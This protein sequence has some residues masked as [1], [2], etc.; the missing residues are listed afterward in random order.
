MGGRGS[1]YLIN[2][3]CDLVEKL[4]DTNILMGGKIE[5]GII[6]YPVLKEL[7]FLKSVSGIVGKQARDAIHD[8]HNNPTK[9]KLIYVE[10]KEGQEVDDFLIDY[11]IH[12]QLKLHTLDLSLKLKAETLG[13]QVIFPY[14]GK[15]LYTGIT[16]LTD[17]EYSDIITESS[18]S[19]PPINHFSI[20]GKQAFIETHKGK[21]E[22]SYHKFINAH[23]GNIKPRN[24]EQYCLFELLKREIP[25]IM[26]SGTYGTG[27]SYTLLNHAIKQLEENKIQ[28]LVV[29]P[30]NSS[31]ESSMEVAALPG[32]IFEKMAPYTNVLLD[33]IPMYELEEYI[34]VG[35]IEVIPMAVLRGRNLENSIVWV[36]EAQNLHEEHIRLI[37][38]RI[39]YNTQ[40]LIDCDPVQSDKRIFSTKSG[41]RLISRLS[42]TKFANLFGMVTLK[43]IERSSVAQLAEI[44]GNLK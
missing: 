33:M 9:Y 18:K 35:K 2:L 37:L 23:S 28:K 6:V 15:E 14:N 7:N 4:L 12:N 39:G 16:Y 25:I 43:R 19:S 26:A 1:D 5:E 38:G 24:I 3:G 22:I 32:S 21:E 41:I 44:L 17:E 27:K 20:Y 36:S 40:L 42:E 31:L 10:Q 13:C 34:Q 30:N 11:A 29:I 8:I